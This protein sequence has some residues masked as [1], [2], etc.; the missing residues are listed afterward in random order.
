[1]ESL[2][3]SVGN[4]NRAQKVDLPIFVEAGTLSQSATRKQGEVVDLACPTDGM[5]RLKLIV[6]GVIRDTS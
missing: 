1:M 3:G 6:V 5:G 4:F 2:I